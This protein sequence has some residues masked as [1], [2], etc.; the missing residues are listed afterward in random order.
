MSKL[1]KFS[2][3]TFGV[4]KTFWFFGY[5]FQDFKHTSYSWTMKSI[6]FNDCKTTEEHAKSFENNLS[7]KVVKK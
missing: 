4:R 3:G 2:D 1:V 6:N 7:Y 5:R